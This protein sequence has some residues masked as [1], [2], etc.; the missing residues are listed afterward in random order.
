MTEEKYER[1]AKIRK[2]LYDIET[3]LTCANSVPTKLAFYYNQCAYKIKD[4]I[5]DESYNI[6]WK[7]IVDDLQERHRELESEFESL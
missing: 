3:L 1:A 4:H 6:I 7:L 2:E 5:T